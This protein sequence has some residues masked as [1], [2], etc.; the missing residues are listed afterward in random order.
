MAYLSA[1][2]IWTSHQRQHA[3]ALFFFIISDSKRELYVQ[4]LRLFHVLLL[5]AAAAWPDP[6][7]LAV[8]T[9]AYTVAL[10]TDMPGISPLTRPV[11]WHPPQKQYPGFQHAA[12]HVGEVVTVMSMGTYRTC[13]HVSAGLAGM[14]GDDNA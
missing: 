7:D 13:A 3:A 5:P 11:I 10:Q 9:H 8:T 1:Y 2:V 12:V 4:V 14:F 6:C